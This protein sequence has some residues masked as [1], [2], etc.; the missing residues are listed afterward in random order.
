[1][2]FYEESELL[3]KTERGETRRRGNV[4]A[5]K[6]HFIETCEEF[7]QHL[8]VVEEI[9]MSTPNVT[10]LFASYVEDPY[11]VDHLAHWMFTLVAKITEGKNVLERFNE[12][13]IRVKCGDGDVRQIHV[14]PGTLIG[15]RGCD[16]IENLA[17]ALPSLKEG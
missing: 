12:E 7:R 9:F 14:V 10:C 2:S 16:W 1:M 11:K 4:V 5:C 17:W 13:H 6:F 15:M 3:V 8:S